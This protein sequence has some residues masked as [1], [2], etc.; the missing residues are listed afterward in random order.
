MSVTIGLIIAAVY[1]NVAPQAVCS[2]Y[3]HP[4]HGELTASGVVYDMYAMTGAHPTLPLGSIVRFYNTETGVYLDCWIIDRG[5]YA[6]DSDG[7]AKFP[8]EPHPTRQF[9]L[10]IACFDSLGTLDDGL[11]TLSYRILRRDTRGLRWN[12]GGCEESC[13]YE[14]LDRW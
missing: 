12:L 2:H 3:G 14:R 7:Y 9:D 4:F 10:S 5:P 13:Y 6:T 8:L 1:W 11:I